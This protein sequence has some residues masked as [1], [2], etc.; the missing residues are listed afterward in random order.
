MC[1]VINGIYISLAVVP[2]KPERSNFHALLFDDRIEGNV[3][4]GH[5]DSS[6]LTTTAKPIEINLK[7]I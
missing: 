1:S 4:A 6:S 3:V 7:V 2:F 5:V